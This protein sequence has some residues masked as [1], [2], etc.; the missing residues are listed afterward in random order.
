VDE[1]VRR[2]EVGRVAL[3]ALGA[4][5][6]FR[7]LGQGRRTALWDAAAVERRAAGA[8]PLFDFAVGEAPLLA[9]PPPLLPPEREGEAVVE[10]YL[11]AGLTLRR[12]PLA[13]LRPV[14]DRLGLQ[15]TRRLAAQRQGSWLRL[16]GLVL[17]RQRP[18]TAKGVIFVTVEDE[19]GQGNIVVYAQIAERDRTA[20][21]GARLLVVEGRVERAAEKA[22]VPIIHLIARTLVDRSDLLE[23]LREAGNTDWAEKTL[24][25]ADEVKRPDPG[26]ARPNLGRSRDFR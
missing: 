7:S 20:L 6:A 13:L 21:V 12:H 14:L 2:A 3:E 18:G 19:H 24:G 5:D 8:G 11:A 9:E 22:E 17:M 25:R 15:D 16:A 1:L 10:D 23:G 26:S 4:A